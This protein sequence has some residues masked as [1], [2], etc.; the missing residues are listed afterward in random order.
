MEING[1]ASGYASQ[2]AK[3]E[4]IS[5]KVAENTTATSDKKVDKFVK[6]SQTENVTYQKSQKLSLDELRAAETQRMQS[7][8]NML[9]SMIVKQG[10]KSNLTMFGKNFNVT[11]EQSA[12]AAKA[13]APGGEYSVDSVATRLLDMAKALSG[14]DKSK[15]S[16]LRNAVEKGFK[17][18]GIDFGKEL[19]S[20]CKDTHDE[21]MKRFDDWE[22]EG[23]K[24]VAVDTEE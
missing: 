24:P 3:N 19:P 5:K 18:A 7:F 17:A 9:R 4:I 16:L 20:I 13:I 22:N 8:Q 23:T 2:V 15:I 1:V 6:S 21:V 10:E 14:G 12:E 11:P